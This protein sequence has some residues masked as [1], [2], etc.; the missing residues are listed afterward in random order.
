MMARASS[1]LYFR[2]RCVNQTWIWLEVR[3]I[4]SPSS[5]RTSSDGYW[6]TVDV[7]ARIARVRFQSREAEHQAEDRRR[8]NSDSRI[9]AVGH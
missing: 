7:R 4:L 5:R 1:F 6:L 3:L 2:R 9:Q 8:K